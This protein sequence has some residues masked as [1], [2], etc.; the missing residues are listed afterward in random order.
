MAVDPHTPNALY[1]ATA[2]AG[3]YHSIDGGATWKPT[4]TN[5]AIISRESIVGAFDFMG[6]GVAPGE[7]AT[8]FGQ[9]IGPSQGIAVTA[10]DPATGKLPTEVGGVRVFFNDIPAPL[11]YVSATQ[12][13]AQVPFEVAG[14]NPA[15]VNVRVEFD[16]IV[17]NTPQVALLATHPGLYPKA[18]N[19]SDGSLNSETATTP[20]GSYVLLYAT[21]QGETDQPVETGATPPAMEPF[22]RPQAQVQV[23]IGGQEATVYFA[24]LVAPFVGLMQINVQIPAGLAPG[25]YDVELHIGN[26]AGGA[27][28]TV[29]VG[30]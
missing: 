6:G 25:K 14:A 20:A 22:A 9:G 12:V 15:R 2:G 13:N 18:V 21:G 5:A 10:F 19:S 28:G 26:A 16:G 27:V 30:P 4:G 17:S 24:G 7:L 3:V 23:F 1:A 11:L 8:I 29:W